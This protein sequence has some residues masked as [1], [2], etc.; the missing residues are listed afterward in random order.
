MRIASVRREGPL[1]SVAWQ[2][3]ESGVMTIASFIS[4]YQKDRDL[5]RSRMP[6]GDFIEVFLNVSNSPPG[7]N[8]LSVPVGEDCDNSIIQTGS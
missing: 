6:A 7:K 5:V 4:P 3:M 1:S 2:Q 8:P